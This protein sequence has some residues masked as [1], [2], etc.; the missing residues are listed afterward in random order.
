VSLYGGVSGANRRLVEACL[1]G[2]RYALARL[3]TVV[4]D[5]DPDAEGILDHVFPRAG[6]ALRVGVTGPPGAGKSTL[7]AGMV[8]GLR[9]EGRRVGVVAV[10]PSSP[11]SRGAL[12]GDRIRLKDLAGDPDLFVRSMATR[13][14]LGGL[15]R[16]TREVCDLLDAF[17]LGTILVETV[18]VGQSELDVASAADSVV[19]VLVPESGDEVQA[20]KAGL[21]EIGDVFVVNKADRPG[22][23]RIVAYLREVI[24]AHPARDGW[25]PPVVAAVA[26]E[27]AGVAEALEAL[28]RHRAHLA[29]ADRLAARRR[30][31]VRRDVEERVLRI[32]GERRF[33]DAAVARRIAEG[34]DRILRREESPYR[35][36]REVADGIE[37]PRGE[38]TEAHPR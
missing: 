30:A 32:L 35:L 29:A 2:D 34:V 22:A 17:G 3:I 5:C 26:Q 25:R 12:L 11:F 28:V 36:A 7:V 24:D 13:G 31:V 9:A 27:G 15:A 14:S 4:E 6:G 16:T 38:R 19:V 33:G 8:R 23:D 37:S 1:G 18:G 21:M 10:D 20:M